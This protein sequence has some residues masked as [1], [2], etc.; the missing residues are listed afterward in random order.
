MGVRVAGDAAMFVPRARAIA[1]E[2]D[3]GLRLGRVE[4]LSEAAWNQDLEAMVG[5]VATMG[6]VVLGLC[7]SAAAIYALMSVT[8]AR[9]TREIGLRSAL[10]GTPARVLL[11]V[12]SHAALLVGGGIAAGN[13][14]LAIV[15][16][17]VTQI[18]PW[19]FV[20]VAL[21]ITSVVMV[22]V[23]ALACVVPARRALQINPTDALRQT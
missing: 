1:S 17:Q 22:A 23:G 2:V 10:G 18:Y 13:L 7:L 11:G 6:A 21:L 12:F 9:R 15:A 19:R 20:A 3:P 16:T 4:A 5:A 8:V 14:L